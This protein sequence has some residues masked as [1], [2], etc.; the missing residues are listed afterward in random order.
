MDRICGA[1]S[2]SAALLLQSDVRTPDVPRTASIDEATRQHF[3]QDWHLRDPRAV[4]FPRMM[5]G[6]IVTDHDLLTPEQIESDPMYNEI[7][8]PSGFHWFAGVGFWADSAAWALTIQ[9]TEREGPFEDREKKLLARLAPR[10]TET[11]TL[12]TT[13]GRIALTSITDVL[14]HVRQPALVLDRQGMVLSTNAAA[15]VGFDEEIRV[16]DRRLVVRDKKAVAKLDRLMDL[17]RSAPEATAL[18]AS[19]ILVRR[20][21]K[22]SV[23]IRVLPVDGPARNA[24]LGAR[25]LLVFSNLTPRLAPDPTLIAQALDLSP[26]ESRVAALLATG[27]SID[28][29]AERLCISR[30]T[31]RN[32]VKAAFS[33]TGT[34]RQAE[35]ISLVSQ[36]I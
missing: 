19:P 16:R 32:H 24:F 15:D 14:S 36:L 8:I 25:V 30:E 26:A 35:L 1:V 3:E 33:K 18:S 23:V 29:A 28:V 21:A 12:A 13:I 9:R 20:T 7:L 4:G 6:E 17:V 27:F 5:S 2:A 22:P 11:A 31:A 10:L 34:H